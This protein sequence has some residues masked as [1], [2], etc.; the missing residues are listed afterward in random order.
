MIAER[1]VL[2]R[3][4]GVLKYMRIPGPD[5]QQ[6][7]VTLV[8]LLV[9]LVILSIALTVVVPTMSN[10]YEKWMLR[11]AARRTVA[12]FRFASDVARKK[13]T[14]ITGYYADHGV[15]LADKGSVFKR[16]EIPASITVRP[17]KPRAAVFLPT[18]QIISSEP[19]VLESQRGKKMVLEFGPLP[20]EVSLKE[21]TP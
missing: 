10:S 19:F 8:E 21:A 1:F 15:L 18:G 17:E 20:G 7:G 3:A 2:F 5:R 13:G 6:R 9:V 11:S 12:L 4:Y 14:N 16:L